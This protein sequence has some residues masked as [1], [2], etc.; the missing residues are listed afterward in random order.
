MPFVVA[1]T[2]EHYQKRIYQVLERCEGVLCKMDD[3]LVHSPNQLGNVIDSQVGIQADP[4]KLKAIKS[5]KT[6]T[7][8]T[9]LRRFLGMVNQMGKFSPNLAEKSKPL[10]ELLSTKNDW[11]QWNSAHKESFNKVKKELSSPELSSYLPDAS[12]YGLG[13]V[14]TVAYAFRAIM[15]T[16]QPYAQIEKEAFASTWACEKSAD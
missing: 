7:D 5:M 2:P 4:E 1:S 13:A 12:S 15:N 16:E 10:R 6:P 9:E 8:H 14:I 3:I 11:I